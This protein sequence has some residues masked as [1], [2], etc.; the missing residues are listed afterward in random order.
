MISQPRHPG[1]WTSQQTDHIS[2][3]YQLSLLSTYSWGIPW[4]PQISTCQ[5]FSDFS[6]V[7]F[8]PLHPH[9]HQYTSCFFS[10]PMHLAATVCLFSK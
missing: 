9:F 10:G 8:S 6:A 1:C 3:A 7:Q 4:Y 2:P 5:M